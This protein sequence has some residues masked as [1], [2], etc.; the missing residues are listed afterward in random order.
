MIDSLS[1]TLII[2]LAC[3]IFV[4]LLFVFV[5]SF[6]GY[7]YFCPMLSPPPP[8]RLFFLWRPPTKH[9]N[10]APPNKHRPEPQSLFCGNFSWFGCD[11]QVSRSS[12]MTDLTSEP[13]QV[14]SRDTYLVMQ[15]WQL[16]AMCC[17]LFLPQ[18]KY[19]W[20]LKAHLCR[21]ADTKWVHCFRLIPHL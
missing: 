14:S 15:A 9:Q 12:S 19:L 3:F 5:V 18:Q 6:P 7:F 2:L 8:T 13:V 20:Y 21:H 4:C 1:F 16:L 11:A 10:H 17:V